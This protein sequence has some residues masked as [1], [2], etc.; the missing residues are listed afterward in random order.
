MGGYSCGG[1][2]HPMVTSFRRSAK[3]QNVD[4]MAGFSGPRVFQKGRSESI[5]IGS[6]GLYFSFQIIRDGT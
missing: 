5:G 6:G 3:Y 1:N 4:Y 2:P